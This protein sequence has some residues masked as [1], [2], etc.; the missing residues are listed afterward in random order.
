MGWQAWTVVGITVLMVFAMVRH[1]VGPDLVLTAA[2]ACVLALGIVTPERALSGF[3]NEGVLTVAVLF[4]VA[5]G[6]R[7]TGAL[8]YAARRL[9]GRPRHLAAAQ[10]RLMLPVAAISAFLN[11]TPVVALM[12][13][14]VGD[15]ARRVKLSSSKLLIPLSYAA[16]LG[17]SCT[18]IGTSTNLIAV[19]MARDAEPQLEV[20]MFDIAWLGVPALLVGMVFIVLSARWLLPE[21]KTGRE[22]LSDPREY[23]VAMRVGD[24]AAIV[25]RSIEA[26]GLR[27]L[28]GLYLVEIERRDEPLVAVAPTTKLLAGDV[29]VFAGLVESVVDLRKIRGLV[30]ASDQVQ[31]FVRSTRERRLVEAVVGAGSDLVG[32]SVRDAG[33]RTR[34]GAAIM[35]VHRGGQRI[36]AKVG[37]IVLEAGDTLLLEAHPGF[38]A[39]HRH[40]RSFALVSEV[41]GSAP[42]S[43]E[44]APVAVLLL[45]AMVGAAVVG[46]VPL[47]TAAL[48]AAGGLLVTGCLSGSEARASLDLRV[49]LAIASSFGLAAALQDSGAATA[50]AGMMTGL[51]A[52]GG[53]VAV[54]FA[55]FAATALMAS[56]VG[57]NASVAIMFPIAHATAMAPGM[58]FRPCLFVLMLAASACFAS[59]ISY[60][61]NLMVYGPGGYRFGDF[62]RVGL[63]LQILVG[64][65][66]VFVAS[67]RWL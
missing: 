49:L 67:W 27:H 53:P 25:G 62:V 35:A 7:E 34:F 31:K 64:V 19:G 51:A 24:D 17:G 30:A 47:F 20:G 8:D 16:I 5:A 61:T 6:L 33:F 43:H 11:N 58:S 54:L 63:P 37:D 10:L 39:R 15:W 41:E 28:P 2:M 65:V 42:L 23:T 12:V 3:S 50:V 18:L 56:L 57:N 40:S 32:R 48:L 29:L 66:A 1:R 13:P 26:A 38:V 9:L 52:P 45:L 36:V 21:R 59:P 14:L 4:V 46:I 22:A 55:L 44:K 60:Q